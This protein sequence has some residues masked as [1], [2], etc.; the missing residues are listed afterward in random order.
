MENRDL[1]LPTMTHKEICQVE[2][3]STS[4][5]AEMVRSHK[6]GRA[7]GPGGC[8]LQGCG[9]DCCFWA[10][11]LGKREINCQGHANLSKMTSVLQRQT[12]YRG[13]V[14]SCEMAKTRDAQTVKLARHG[15]QQRSLGSRQVNPSQTSL[16]CGLHWLMNLE[17]QT[18]SLTRAGLGKTRAQSPQCVCQLPQFSSTIVSPQNVHSG[19][20]QDELAPLVRRRWQWLKYSSCLLAVIASRS[21]VLCPCGKPQRKYEKVHASQGTRPSGAC[22]QEVPTGG[23]I[24][25][26]SLKGRACQRQGSLQAAQTSGQKGTYS[27]QLLSQG[28]TYTL[29]LRAPGQ[30]ILR[31]VCI[32]NMHGVSQCFRD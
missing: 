20:L 7:S 3:G 30:G 12:E 2:L 28:D 26:A 23:R 24:K 9:R 6:G 29:A 31:K 32:Q 1:I 15:N 25:T 5:Q 14:Q 11:G 10:E 21:R 13:E 18:P 22:E 19:W 16:F 17:G 4:L 27:S 8:P